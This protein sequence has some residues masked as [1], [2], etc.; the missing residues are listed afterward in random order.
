MDAIDGLRALATQTDKSGASWSFRYPSNPKRF[1]K[2][3]ERL[4]E[5]VGPT[6]N[7]APVEFAIPQIVDEVQ[8]NEEILSCIIEV[9]VTLQVVNK[10]ENGAYIWKGTN[11]IW[12]CLRKKTK[13]QFDTNASSKTAGNRQLE[14]ICSHVLD[15]LSM[16][17]EPVSLSLVY[18]HV[19]FRLKTEHI[20]W[21]YQG[22]SQTIY[23]ISAVLV[24]IGVVKDV[25][26]RTCIQYILNTHPQ[27]QRVAEKI[28]ELTEHGINQPRYEPSYSR[29]A[30]GGGG[31]SGNMESWTLHPFSIPVELDSHAE[32]MRAMQN[33]GLSPFSCT[34]NQQRDHNTTSPAI[35][36]QSAIMKFFRD[37]F[38]QAQIVDI[39]SN[40][41]LNN[42]DRRPQ[43]PVHPSTPL[44][45]V[46]APDWMNQRQQQTENSI[47][48]RQYNHSLSEVP[49][50]M[51]MMMIQNSRARQQLFN[52]F[53]KCLAGQKVQQQDP[54]AFQDE[55]YS[56]LKS[57]PLN[58]TFHFPSRLD[59]FAKCLKNSFAM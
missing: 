43:N 42:E 7:N 15:A 48:S 9:L 1:G 18:G 17:L 41:S 26:T 20:S 57:L 51:M 5:Y 31:G 53:S 29:G 22:L 23:C 38:S 45:A 54:F 35:P 56:M 24:G 8:T 3:V 25:S 33:T 21:D 36:M 13:L 49:S 52:D 44:I 59:E 34:T 46:Q 58:Q 19:S 40:E 12:S 4:E 27:Q 10:R 30:S 32:A 14:R 16:H 2:I 55:L 28:P 47:Q 37:D 39:L 11:K 50:M 6:Q